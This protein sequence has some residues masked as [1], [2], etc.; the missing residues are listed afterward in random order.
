MWGDGL[1]RH[2]RRCRSGAAIY[3]NQLYC[4]I[5]AHSLGLTRANW[6]GADDY[7]YRDLG[8]R[9]DLEMSD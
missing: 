5:I 1:R 8:I 3:A 2:G 7:Q 6:R 9:T 4:D